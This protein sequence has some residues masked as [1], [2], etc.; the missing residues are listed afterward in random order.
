[1]ILHS[2]S[3][4][5]A[6]G[7]CIFP[8]QSA[9]TTQTVLVK[10]VTQVS[11]GCISRSPS[12]QGHKRHSALRVCIYDCPQASAGL[13]FAH[14]RHLIYL[15][16]SKWPG[17]TLAGKYAHLENFRAYD[18]RLWSQL[19]AT[20]KVNLSHLPPPLIPSVQVLI[21]RLLQFTMLTWILTA[22]KTRR[23][24]NKISFASIRTET[25]VWTTRKSP[26][27]CLPRD[28]VMHTHRYAGV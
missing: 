19:Q 9:D 15:V 1:M 25:A 4:T 18:G 2:V 10:A 14:F 12:L 24:S 22:A 3:Q 23:R 16:L 28:Q 20:F 7:I 5:V 13:K 27:V 6:R 17:N 11:S 26:S 8:L 21:C